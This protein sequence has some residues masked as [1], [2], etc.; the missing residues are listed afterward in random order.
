MTAA[1]KQA[2]CPQCGKRFTPWRA[3]RF[4]S[5]VCKRKAQNARFRGLSTHGATHI[6]DSQNPEELLS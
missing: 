6:A 3:K 2:A 5:E 4:C 1:A